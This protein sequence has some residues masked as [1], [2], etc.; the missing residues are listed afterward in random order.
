MALYGFIGI[1]IY[2]FIKKHPNESKNMLVHANDLI[3]YMPVDKGTT[4]LLSP[5]MDFTTLR[6]NLQDYNHYHQTIIP[7]IIL[8]SFLI[9][10]LLVINLFTATQKNA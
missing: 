6:E 2:M 5:I 10:Q 8:V 9:F 4:D 1:S 3:R 7:F